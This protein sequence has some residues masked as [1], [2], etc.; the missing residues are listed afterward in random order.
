VTGREGSGGPLAVG[1]DDTL[2]KGE[3]V[4][5][6]HVVLGVVGALGA[7]GEAPGIVDSNMT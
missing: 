4:G 2:A 1:I 5:V 6:C 3:E 7:D